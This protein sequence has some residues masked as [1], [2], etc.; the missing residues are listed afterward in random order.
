MLLSSSDE[1]PLTM[2]FT[3]FGPDGNFNWSMTTKRIQDVA[4]L[5]GIPA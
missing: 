3:A 1:A 5:H 2:S 4:T